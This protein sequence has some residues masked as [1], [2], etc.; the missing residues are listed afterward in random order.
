M[1]DQYAY[2]LNGKK[3]EYFD[4]P[5]GSLLWAIKQIQTGKYRIISNDRYSEKWTQIGPIL[6]NNI[7]IEGFGFCK[8]VPLD[9]WITPKVK[10]SGGFGLD[11]L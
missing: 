1:N 7:L 8:Y 9:G 3:I 4:V 10:S 5:E 2:T 6:E 11:P